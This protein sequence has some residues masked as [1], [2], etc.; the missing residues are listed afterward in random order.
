MAI[1]GKCRAD[2][3]VLVVVDLQERLGAAMPGKV[4]NRVVRNA[5]LLATAC[6]HLDIPVLR[7]EQYP[8]GLGPTLEKVAA[9]LPAGA[10]SF[11][12]TAF[13]CVDADGF[14]AALARHGRGQVLLVGMEAHV[15]VLQTALDLH[16]AGQT[17][18]VVEDAVCSRRLENYQNALERL[19]QAGIGIV[20]AESAV[21]EWVGDAAHPHFKAL[22]ALMR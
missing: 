13:S 15:C 16:A 22:Q 7:S 5:A 8:A 9:K 4:L 11:A 14:M 19:R 21:F 1:A 10:E 3:A 17:V 2:D 18:F 12:K 20:S 6:D